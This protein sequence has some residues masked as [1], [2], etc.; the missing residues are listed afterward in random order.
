MA[1]SVIG[2]SS[3]A[4][5]ALQSSASSSR[6]NS[7]SSVSHSLANRLMRSYRNTFASVLPSGVHSAG[8]L[9]RHPK[10]AGKTHNNNATQRRHTRSPA[11]NNTLP[12]DFHTTTQTERSTNIGQ[13]YRILLCD[14]VG[15]QRRRLHCS[16][17]IGI[18]F[19]SHKQR[20]ILLY[21]ISR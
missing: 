12:I 14:A 4:N 13:S 3:S 6:L 17:F 16:N 1:G 21:S 9:F 20:S 8:A 18:V 7:S 15:Q 2:E 10:T 5:S 19:Q 11:T